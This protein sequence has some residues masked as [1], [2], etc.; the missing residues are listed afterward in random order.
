MSFRFPHIDG[1]SFWAGFIA[2]TILWWILGLLRPTLRQIRENATAKRQAARSRTSTSVEEHYRQIIL[3]KAQGMHLSAP[4]FSLEEIVVAPHLLAPPVRV[5]PGVTNEDDDIVAITLPYLPSWAEIASIYQAPTLTLSEAL[6]GD[7]DIVLA[8]HAGAGKTVALA[9]LASRLARREQVPGLAD[10][11]LPLI[12]HV[13]DLN[14]PIKSE[15][16]VLT[17]LIELIL[18]KASI[19]DQSRL[20]DFIRTAFIDGRILL[21]LDGTDELTPKGLEEAIEF[22]KA[23]KRTFPGTHIV[24]TANPEYL[25]GLVSL[26]FV[27]FT[28]ATWNDSQFGEFL[29]KWSDVWT[30]FVNVEA[31]AQT[32]PEQVDTLILNSWLK[33]ESALLTPLEFTLKTWGLYAG[34]LRGPRPIDFIESHVHRLTPSNAPPEALELLALQVTVAME[35]VFEPRKAHE[36]IKE[37]EPVEVAPDEENIDSD[38]NASEEKNTSPKKSTKQDKLQTPSTSLITKMASSG[39]LIQHRNNRMRFLNPVFGGFLAGKALVNYSAEK[40]LDQPYSIGKTLSLQYLALFGEPSPLSTKLLQKQDRPLERN[41]FTVARWLKDT[42]RDAA[43]RGPVMARLA[44]LL[45][46][47]GQPLALRGQSLAAIIMSGD[48]SAALLLRQLCEAEFPELLQLCSLGCGALRDT[49][50]IPTLNALLSFPS[51]GVRRAACL[52]LVAIG[53]TPA[54]EAVASV[55]LHGDETT[56]RNAAEAM[57]NHAGEGHAMLKEAATMDDV[58]VRHAAAH[59]LGRVHQPW[60]DE[61]LARMQIEDSEW[62]VRN[63]ATEVIEKRQR[64]NPHIPKRLPPPSESPWLIEYAGKQGLGVSPDKPSTGLLLNALK[65]GTEDEQLAALS[66]LRM[67]P[68]EGVFGALYQAMYSGG[69]EL[70]EAVFHTFW[71]MAARGVDVPDPQQ[72]GVG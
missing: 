47:E 60:A 35:P 24:T 71:E 36:W 16:D 21:L 33:A 11:T 51:P 64:P 68:T 57:A 9:Y 55:L 12:V 62:M 39:L 48:P 5:E 28:I 29:G 14:L 3:Q 37:F 56:R 8:G 26:N 40:I 59:G 27:P 67:M 72:F 70:R 63:A 43:W 65:S 19:F 22:I 1:L 34:D 66:Y 44:K 32:G 20:P 6:S 58:L 49:K 54:L 42:P 38:E 2:A 25:D 7:S 10:D 46:H 17:P 30:R 53:N 18:E 41:L 15:G 61:I 45:Q 52:A 23:I 4:L 50:A 13:A 31:W 69:A